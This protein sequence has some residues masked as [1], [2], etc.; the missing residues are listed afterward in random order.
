VGFR[1][2]GAEAVAAAQPAAGER[3]PRQ[4]P[5]VVLGGDGEEIALDATDEHRV[6]G[7]LGDEAPEPTGAGHPLR[8]DDLVGGVGG[9]AEGDDLAGPLEVGQRRQR[10]LVARRRVGTVDLVEVDAIRLQPAQAVLDLPHQPPP[11][12]ATHVAVLTHRRMGL[13]GEHDV[14]AAA[15]GEGCADDLLG[16]AGRVHVGGVDEVDAGIE[17]AM[18]DGDRVVVVAVAPGAEHHGA[19]AQRADVHPCRSECAVLHRSRPSSSGSVG[20]TSV[21]ARLTG[22]RRRRS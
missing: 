12:V 7:L 21:V 2:V 8:L 13:G 18:D 22:G 20:G 9:A 16:F 19:E 14:V 11:G 3:A 1:D 15:S 17:G 10:L 5:H 6:R 4:H